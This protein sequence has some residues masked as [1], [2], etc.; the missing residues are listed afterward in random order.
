MTT[1]TDT[2]T[3]VWISTS[4][5]HSILHPNSTTKPRLGMHGS[6]AIGGSDD[7]TNE[8][9]GGTTIN[10]GWTSASVL[11]GGHAG[12]DG[13]LDGTSD[14]TIVV[15]DEESEYNRLELIVPGSAISDGNVVMS[16]YHGDDD[17]DDSL[18]GYD[19]DSQTGDGG[20][21]QPRVNFHGEEA[22]GYP[23]DLIT[24]TH[25]HEPAVVH[26]LR[27]RYNKDLIYTN[28]GPILI[29]LNPFKSCKTLYSDKVRCETC[30]G[31]FYICV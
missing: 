20:N 28:T 2:S 25:L 1:T 30:F 18:N 12:S 11:S 15:E 4:T 23:N 26:C 21:G 5:I 8:T 24:L 14:I 17:D 7:T 27:K 6:L 29:A 22:Q 9:S 31:D 13:A 16:N 19:S 3:K 10:W